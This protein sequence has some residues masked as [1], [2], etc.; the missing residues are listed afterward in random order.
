MTLNKER[1]LRSAQRSPARRIVNSSS[2]KAVQTRREGTRTFS[3]SAMYIYKEGK[4]RTTIEANG[5]NRT[6][7]ETPVTTG[8]YIGTEKKDKA[9]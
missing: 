1:C 5:R 2:V 6:K 7:E 9:S 8:R 3:A 4:I